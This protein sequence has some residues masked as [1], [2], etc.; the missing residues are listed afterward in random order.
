MRR[1]FAGLRDRRGGAAVEMALIAPFLFTLVIGLVDLGVFMFRW[2]QA[3]E[4]TRIGARIAAVSNPVSSDLSTLTGIET[5]V[6]PGQP[7]GAYQRVCAAGACSG[8]VYNAAAFSRIYHGP[9]SACG[10]ATNR[11]TTG[12]CDAF[13]AL[14]T[15]HVTVRYEAS[16]VDS[17]GVAGALRPLISVKVSGAP[18]GVALIGKVF[19]S[20]FAVLPDAETTVMAEDMKSGA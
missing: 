16:G 20:S 4:A 14:Q 17:A 10:D 12:M 18:S 1:L 6:A 3:V 11:D 5:G 19:A 9:G 7:V 2:N 13:S 8:G 15:A